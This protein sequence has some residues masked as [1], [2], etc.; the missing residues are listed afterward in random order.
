VHFAAM[1]FGFQL[2]RH[3]RFPESGILL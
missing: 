2:F 3:K 1:R